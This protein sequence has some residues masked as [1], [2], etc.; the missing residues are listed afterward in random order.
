MYCPN[1]RC[2]FYGWKKSCPQCQSKLLDEP[3][4][5]EKGINKRLSY[6]DL[7]EFV[8]SQGGEIQIDV[9]AAAVK[10][11]RRWR[12]PYIGH[13]YAWTEKLHGEMDGFTV[14]LETQEVGRSRG[15]NFPYF[16][17]GYAWMKVIDG[18]LSGN[19]I[20][21][22]ASNVRKRRRQRF[23]YRGNGF[24]WAEEMEGN[25]GDQIKS[26]LKITEVGRKSSY[27]FPY[28]GYGFA[29]EKEGTLILRLVSS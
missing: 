1:C 13:G 12:F 5:S 17:Y 27:Q 19:P 6:P 7:V 21:L 4:P 11:E 24:A 22:T 8:R 9:F 23:P 3:P 14:E 28:F 25:C 29:W 2:E 16:G 18:N 15:W 26:H 10:R 20:R